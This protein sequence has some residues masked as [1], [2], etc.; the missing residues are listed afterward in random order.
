MGLTMSPVNQVTSEGLPVLFIKDLPPVSTV[1]LKI[2]R[3]QIYYGELAN[4]Y[5][6][7]GTRQ[8]EFD[9]PSGEKNVYA[10]YTGKGGVPVGNVL[11][12][13]ILAAHFGSSKIL[14]S[15]DITSHSRV[16]YN[17]TIMERAQEGAPFLRFDRDPYLVIA[18]RR[19]AQVDP[20]RLHRHR[21]LSLCPAAQGR[22]QL[23]AEQRQ[24]GDRRLRRLA[25]RRTSARRPI[26]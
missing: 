5:V 12:R 3:P 11:R 25:R 7:V 13:A 17:R 2:T 20:R 26:R 19:H 15:G 4:E 23:H 1:S 21:R 14:F 10:S 22:H 24:A 9:H 8:R 6:F 18:G 16:L